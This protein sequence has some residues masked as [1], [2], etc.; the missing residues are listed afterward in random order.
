MS[1]QVQPPTNDAPIQRK[2]SSW[3]PVVVVVAVV[4]IGLGVVGTSTSGGAGM[5]NYTLQ[6]LAENKSDIGR[7]EIKVSGKVRKGS[8]RGEPGSAQF[9]FDLED[10]QGHQL[11]V[12]YP[13]LLPDPFEEGREAIVQG[14]LDNGELSAS[15]LT[16]KCPSRYADA[17]NMSEADQKKYYDEEYA[18]HKAAQPASK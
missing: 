7:R 15:N 3:A 14:R 11:T 5:Y 10:G 4:G 8:V 9:R 16:V 13:R 1:E 2:K 18:K 6:Q 17:Q 12:A